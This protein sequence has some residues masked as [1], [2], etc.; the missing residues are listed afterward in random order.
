[1]RLLH[2]A[3]KPFSILIVSIYV[4]LLIKVFDFSDCDKG[5]CST[6]DC[7]LSSQIL[8]SVRCSILLSLILTMG[9]PSLNMSTKQP[10]FLI[11]QRC[12]QGRIR[13]LV[14]LDMFS[15][16]VTYYYRAPPLPSD[17]AFLQACS[18]IYHFSILS[19]SL[20]ETA[21]Y[22]LN[23]YLKGPLSPKQPTN[24]PWATTADE[25]TEK[26]WNVSE[27]IHSI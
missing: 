21:R 19:P 23:Y 8:T 3:L 5:E 17:F 14:F 11:I 6:L 15:S 20:W 4:S 18:L 16:G 22:R 26:E 7:H 10:V 2:I 12:C 27:K 24:Q 9:L 1:M 25:Q 13:P